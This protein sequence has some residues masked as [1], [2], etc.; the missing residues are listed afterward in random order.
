VPSAKSNDNRLDA[1]VGFFERK[2]FA[3]SSLRQMPFVKIALNVGQDELS[4]N[5]VMTHLRVVPIIGHPHDVFAWPPSF[6]S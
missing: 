6:T 4:T 1:V 2:E 3:S 5:E